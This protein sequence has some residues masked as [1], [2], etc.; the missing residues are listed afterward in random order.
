MNPVRTAPSPP[1]VPALLLAAALAAGGIGAASWSSGARDEALATLSATQRWH[2][3]LMAEMEALRQQQHELQPALERWKALASAG[4]MQPPDPSAWTAGASR[5]QIRQGIGGDTLR[6]APARLLEDT[7]GVLLISHRLE[8]DAALRHEGRL[9]ALIDAL[10][11]MRGALILPRGC[12]LARRGED[13]AKR[14]HARCRLD[15]L[16][17]SVAT[18]EASR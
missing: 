6:F 14:V 11:S 8:I 1:P 5:I 4:A 9:P 13:A 7:N 16:T 15:W 18:R 3:G 10:A 17:L 12:T 2:A